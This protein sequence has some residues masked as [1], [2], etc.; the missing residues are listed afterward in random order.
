MI[1]TSTTETVPF[2]PTWL[3]RGDGTPNAGAIVFHLRAGGVIERSQLEAKLAG[4]YRAGRVYGFELREAVR[5]GV[6]ALLA[7]DPEMD[8]ILG[9]LDAE[10]ADDDAGEPLTD[11]DVALLTEIRGVLAEGWPAYR[12]LIAQLERRREIAPIV[13][14]SRFCAGWDNGKV[15]FERGRDGYVTEKAMRGID[16]LSMM[17][18]GNRAYAMLYADEQAGNSARPGSSAKD[19]STSPVADSSTA[20]GMSPASTG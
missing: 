1:L 12:D 10:A 17:S 6:T 20:D 3:C 5:T 15:A 13:A 16:P 2:T 11:D 8:R 19:P 9:L 4:E 14:F 18:A 7:D